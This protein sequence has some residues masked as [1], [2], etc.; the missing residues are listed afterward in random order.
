MRYVEDKFNTISGETNNE[1][2]VRETQLNN[3]SSGL[4]EEI[5]KIGDAVR[6]ARADR[7]ENDNTVLRKVQEELGK[8]SNEI[9]KERSAR[10]ASEQAIYELLKDVVS[11]VKVFLFF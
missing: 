2:H 8:N 7:E 3:T 5:N 11:R 4:D 10:E 1:F 6:V 9:N